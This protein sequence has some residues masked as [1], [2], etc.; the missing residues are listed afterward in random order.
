M[1]ARRLPCW[2]PSAEAELGERSRG[3]RPNAAWGERSRA[4]SQQ[5]AY[6]DSRPG[7]PAFPRASR[8]TEDQTI[9]STSHFLKNPFCQNK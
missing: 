3:E 5:P 6:P 9:V 4:P 1:W 7:T 8:K 2:A